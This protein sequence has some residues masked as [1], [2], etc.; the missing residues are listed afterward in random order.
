MDNVSTQDV[1]IIALTTFRP[2]HLASLWLAPLSR[3]GASLGYAT[4]LLLDCFGVASLL[5]RQGEK[6][7]TPNY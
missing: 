3:K 6:V 4:G 1:N 2:S 7:E 5:L